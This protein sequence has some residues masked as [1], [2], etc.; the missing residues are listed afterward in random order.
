MKKEQLVSIIPAKTDENEKKK[1][2]KK[3]QKYN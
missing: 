1:N 2:N 3:Y